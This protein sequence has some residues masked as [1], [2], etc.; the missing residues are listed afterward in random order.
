MS[1]KFIKAAVLGYPAAHSKS[2][3]IHNYW[4]NHYGL[5]GSYEAITSAPNNLKATIQRL[6][7][8]GYKGFNLT[9]PHKESVMQFCDDI[10][11]NAQNIGA[12]NTVIIENNGRLRG[13]NTDGFG[14]LGNIYESDQNFSFEY[15]CAVV[16]GAGGAARAVISALIGEQI[17]K[18]ILCNRTLENAQKLAQDMDMRTGIIE[19]IPWEQRSEALKKA[20]LLI[21]TTSLG[22]SDAGAL[23]IDL[24]HLSSRALVNDIVY[25]PLETPLLK[26]A[27]TRG[28]HVVTGIGMLLHQARPAFNEWFGVMP[29]VTPD[30][31]EL[32]LK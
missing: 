27:R 26:A 30:L 16:L 23:E 31:R 29:E 1:D 17:E 6:K 24:S 4:I 13:L 3:L 7:E 10:D 15:K 12:V 18:I 8:E 20:D 21:N 9:I 5:A 11:L 32:V 28:C 22:M 14:F 19:V 2:P 25:A